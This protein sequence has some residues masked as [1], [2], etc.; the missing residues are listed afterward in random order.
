ME[1][2]IKELLPQCPCNPYGTSV[3]MALEEVKSTVTSQ[4]LK[5]GNT[6]FII[7]DSPPQPEII[8]REERVKFSEKTKNLIKRSFPQENPE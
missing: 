6:Y 1:I 2:G 4:I 5:Y 8:P 3:Q 7:N